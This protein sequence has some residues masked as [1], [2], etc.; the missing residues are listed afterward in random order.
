MLELEQEGRSYCGKAWFL[1]AVSCVRMIAAP[2]CHNVK[3]PKLS[4]VAAVM[5]PAGSCFCR[6][7]ARRADAVAIVQASGG[8]LASWVPCGQ[9]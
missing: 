1:E 5:D 6:S 7:W 4:W 2:A 3:P 9:G 8:G